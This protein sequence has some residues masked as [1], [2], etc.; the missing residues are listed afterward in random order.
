VLDPVAIE[1]QFKPLFRADAKMVLAF[2]ADV[3]IGFEIFFQTMVRQLAH[4]VHRPRS[5]RCARRGHR[6]VDRFFFALEPGHL[7]F[8][9]LVIDPALGQTPLV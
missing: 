6:L 3:K 7:V 5:S 9:A 2:G 8:A 1:Q 4:L